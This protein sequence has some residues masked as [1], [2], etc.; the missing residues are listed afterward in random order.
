MSTEEYVDHIWV[1]Q[2]VNG[3]VTV[4]AKEDQH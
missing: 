2:K 1:G 3:F 4:V